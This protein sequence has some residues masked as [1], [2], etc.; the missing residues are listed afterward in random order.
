MGKHSYRHYNVDSAACQAKRSDRERV[1]QKN[2]GIYH[3]TGCG[4]CQLEYQTKTPQ[5]YG[6]VDPDPSITG[7]VDATIYCPVADMDARVTPSISNKIRCPYGNRDRTNMC[8]GCKHGVPITCQI[9]SGESRIKMFI[10]LFS[11]RNP[12]S[13]EHIPKGSAMRPYVG[14]EHFESR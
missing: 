1:Y 8:V 6:I 9:E 5:E 4:N 14:C 3:C 2:S 12:L 11:C 10:R 7:V 13:S